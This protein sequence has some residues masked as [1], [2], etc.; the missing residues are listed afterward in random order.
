MHKVCKSLEQGRTIFLPCCF[1]RRHQ[2]A[3]ERHGKKKRERDQL[4]GKIS[5]PPGHFRLALCSSFRSREARGPTHSP[6]SLRR[7]GD[8]ARNSSDLH[9]MKTHVR[10]GAKPPAR[11]TMQVANRS[12]MCYFEISRSHINKSKTKQVNFIKCVLMYLKYFNLNVSST[13]TY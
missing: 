7:R 8:V 5:V 13:G 9:F 6:S 12:H 1:V 3:D 10:L 11:N 2:G 4:L